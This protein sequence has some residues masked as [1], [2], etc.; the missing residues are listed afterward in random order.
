MLLEILGVCRWSYGFHW[1]SAFVLDSFVLWYIATKV[2]YNNSTELYLEYV[3]RVEHFL[4][5]MILQK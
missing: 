4:L 1:P 5:Q 3:E 2:S